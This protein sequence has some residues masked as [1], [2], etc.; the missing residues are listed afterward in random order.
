[1]AR[2][3]CFL[4]VC[5]VAGLR[6]PM[7]SHPEGLAIARARIAAEQE[8]RTGFLDLGLLGLEELP[9]K[10]FTLE[11]LWGLNLGDVWRDEW[12]ARRPAEPGLIPNRVSVQLNEL[13]QFPLLR[14]LSVA[15]IKVSD[16]RPLAGLTGLQSFYCNGTQ[17]SDL[18][19]LARFTGLQS[20]DCDGTKVSDLGPLAQLTGL[21]SLSCDSTQ[22]SDLIR[23]GRSMPSIPSFRGKTVLAGCTSFGADSPV[24]C[25]KRWSGRATAW[26]NSSS[27]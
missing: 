1:M 14:L 19:P 11:R 6:K 22:V 10:L 26:M 25:S 17:V 21:Q 9:E 5:T 23:D 24:R 16:L 3:R 2:A 27:L 18:S 4:V 13:E 7:S 20:L 8:N 15:G 12:G